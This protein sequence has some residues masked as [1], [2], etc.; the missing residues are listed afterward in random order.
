MNEN[1][2]ISIKISL[3]FVPKGPGPI[4]NIQ[5]LVQIMA[6]RRPGDKPLS[7]PMLVSL[8]THICVTR[9]QWVNPL[10]LQLSCLFSI[11][12]IIQ[13]MYHC[14][15]FPGPRKLPVGCYCINLMIQYVLSIID[16]C[17]C[18]VKSLWEI[19]E[20]Q[21]TQFL[22]KK[23]ISY[24]TWFQKTSFNTFIVLL[25]LDKLIKAFYNGEFVFGVFVYFLTA[26]D[27]VN[28]AVLF[29]K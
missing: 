12:W 9:P 20:Q 22:G 10:M 23:S 11:F 26:F 18:N 24:T 4:N 25:A 6:W 2:R 5:A 27:T 15:H 14:Q 21:L 13:A 19:F 7:A 1:V 16:L 28:N 8:L 29:D 17:Y 3:K